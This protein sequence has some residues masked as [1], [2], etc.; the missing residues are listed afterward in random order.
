LGKARVTRQLTVP[1]ASISVERIEKG[2]IM[3]S[4]D[5]KNALARVQTDYGFYISCQTD[6]A[7]A[8]SGYDLRPDERSTLMNTEKLADLLIQGI[9]ITIS[10]TH[11]WVN[12][13]APK[14]TEKETE[15]EKDDRDA[16]VAS[17]VQAIKHASTDDE[18]TRAALRLMDLVG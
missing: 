12:R 14:K 8:L 11:D 5:F 16:L 7:R 2:A 15:K 3:A 4:E 13:A 6:P 18:R 1:K 10:G 9:S 17:A